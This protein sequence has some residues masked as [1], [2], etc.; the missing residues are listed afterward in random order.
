MLTARRRGSNTRTLSA[1]PGAEA[2]AAVE[3]PARSGGR[4]GASAPAAG[5]PTGP[6]TGARPVPSTPASHGL[7]PRLLSYSMGPAAFVALLV[8]RHLGL[9][10]HLP[11]VTYIGV[12][13]GVPAV[14]T[15]IESFYRRNPNRL[16]LHMR[17][18][19]HT[20]RRHRRH[21]SDRLGAGGHRRLRL[22]RPREHRHQRVAHLA[23]RHLLEPG[24][25]RRRPTRHLA[26]LGPV[27]SG[28][29]QSRD[30]GAHGRLRPRLR[31]PHGRG[32][33]R[34]EGGGR[35]LAAH[36]RGTL[37]LPGPEFVRHHPGP[38][39]RRRDPLR[40]PGQPVPARTGTGRAHRPAGLR[41]GPSR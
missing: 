15:F 2:T 26:G 27:V 8:L 34:T 39:P 25:H 37:P 6:A 16:R 9:V 36:E 38:R 5:D 1:A 28:S 33:Q 29:G 32:H 10:A 13:A 30:P 31:H 4:P 41:S 23:D 11:I 18:A 3:R 12:F 14:S 7:G 24:G 17:V 22:R 40:Q 20:G 19:F 21:L 35:D